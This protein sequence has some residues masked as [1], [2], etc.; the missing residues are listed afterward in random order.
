M[1]KF[2]RFLLGILL[3]PLYLIGLILMGFIIIFYIIVQ[4]INLVHQIVFN[5]NEKIF[6]FNGK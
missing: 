2:L 5:S 3:I 1:K 4:L 6:T